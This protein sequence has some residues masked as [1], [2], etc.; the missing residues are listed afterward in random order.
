MSSIRG[1]SGRLA[2]RSL[3]V[4]V[5]LLSALGPG[6][7]FAVTFEADAPGVN[8][9]TTVDKITWKDSKGL[10]REFFFAKVYPNALVP[11]IKGYVTRL[12][13]QPDVASP[14][15]IAEEDP[16][17]INASNAQGWGTNVMH[18]HWSQYGGVNPVF[19]AGFSATTDKRDG[20]DFHQGPVF[21]G[22]HHL[23]FR[24]THKQYTTLLKN[25]IDDRKW[26][27]VTT[28]WFIADGL[29]SVVYAIT[30]DASAGVQS[31]SSAFLNNTLAPY[32]LVSAASWKGTWDWAGSTDAPD[33]QSFG[34]LKRFVTND[35]RNWTYGGTN[36]IPYVW[37]WV[38]PLSG[39]GDAEAA[40]VQTETYAQKQAGEGFGDG[41]DRQGTH[42]PVY[43]DL[44]GS[45]YAFQMNFFDSYNSKRL[46]WGTKQGTLYGGS[47]STPGYAN[48]SLAMCI[49]KYTDHGAAQLI[50]ETEA[51]HSGMISVQAIVGTLVHT[52]REGSGNATAHV[53]SPL[54]YDHVYRTWDVQAAA[55]V[56]RLRF[57]TGGATYKRPVIVVSAFTAAA[58]Q[59]TLN[60]APATVA[61]SLDD[62]GDLLY[63]TLLTTLSGSNLVEITGTGAVCTPVCT[64]DTCGSN[65]CG[66][67]CPCASG[68]VCLANLT[69]CHP[70]A[71]TCGPDGCGGTHGACPV[72]TPTCAPDTCGSNGCGGT[73]AC[74]SGAVC[75]ANLTCC[76]PNANPCG[77]DGCG[78][79]HGT[80]PACGW[81]PGFG[82]SSSR[83]TTTRLEFSVTDATVAT[84]LVEVSGTP[85]RTVN[86]STRRV[87]TGGYV[88]FTGVPASPVAAG[89][90]VRIRATQSTTGGGRT[91][92]S[93]WFP[94]MQAAPVLDCSLA[95]T[96]TCAANTCGN[97]GCGGTCACTAGSVCL[98]NLTCCQPNANTC[99]PDGCGGT[100]GD[101]PVCTPTCAANTCGSNGCGGTCACA[102]GSV[103]LAN[104]TCCQPNANTCGPDG[105]GGTHGACPGTC[106]WDPGF[107]AEGCF[108]G[109]WWLEFSVH[110]TTV[111]TLV[112][113]VASTPARTITL[114]THFDIGGGFVKFTGGPGSPVM[115][116][117]LVRLRATRTAAAGG[118]TATSAWF[119]YLQAPI[120]SCQAP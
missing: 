60:G 16:S 7:S 107:S 25:G 75:L 4:T 112:L 90:L 97:N 91:A 86:L 94:Y 18:M 47:G 44:N 74:T 63:V 14:R 98:A 43:P 24:V 117:T 100:H 6:P 96:P 15:I 37:Q 109:E 50:A 3:A 20:F 113:E 82:T 42:L 34:D 93:A 13:W 51:I 104:L 108:T 68:S 40:F 92:L 65:G 55:N 8:G 81:D 73:C 79:T 1:S 84:M 32:S 21:L 27:S 62:A 67:T 110:D 33:G 9:F 66:G 85:A 17:A 116:G 46:T 69:C 64:A 118:Q 41:A 89:T 83:L 23:I 80:C 52:G 101:C 36:T 77:P 95:C 2:A 78:G 49:G 115:A 106:T 5:A 30:I 45:E 58:A 12:T 120:A 54:G 39:R 111:T 38:T 103:C 35:M 28:D 99:G 31:D 48:Y 87:L 71:N 59:V 105:C 70:N 61:T 22:P 10:D 29:D 11:S 102:S 72:C 119:A 114:P 26:V 19:G 88:R 57:G 76:H 56:A 53:Y